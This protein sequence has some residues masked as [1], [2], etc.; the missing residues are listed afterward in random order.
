MV[1]K[2][3]TTVTQLLAE[4]GIGPAATPPIKIN[5]SND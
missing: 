1:L 3:E 4:K 2:K 5:I